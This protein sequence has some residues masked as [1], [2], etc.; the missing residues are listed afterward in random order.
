M[1]ALLRLFVAWLLSLWTPLD[2]HN[3][4]RTAIFALRAQIELLN[5]K[6]D[7]LEK[8]INDESSKAKTNVSSNKAAATAALQRKKMYEVEL[9]RLNGSRL[10]LEM[11]VHT[12]ES[13]DLNAETVQA[14]KQATLALKGIQGKVTIEGADTVMA[15]VQDQTSIAREIADIISAPVDSVILGAEEDL[16]EELQ[17]LEAEALIERLN[18]AGQVPEASAIRVKQS[19]VENKELEAALA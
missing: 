17:A 9:D 10:Q 13:A 5:K 12:L 3:S 18:S 15:D 6:Q 11:Q 16:R 4:T 8:R 2:T 7:H 19:E 14:M 1:L